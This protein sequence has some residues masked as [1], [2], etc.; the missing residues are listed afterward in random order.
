MK[1]FI[2]VVFIC[3]I[4]SVVLLQFNYSNNIYIFAESK[5]YNVTFNT[6]VKDINFE[7]INN[8][9]YVHSFTSYS[10]A[11]YINKKYTNNI[12]AQTFVYDNDF[13]YKNFLKRINFKCYKKYKVCGVEVFEGYSC[14]LNKYLLKNNHKFNL[15][16]A[17]GEEIKI[18]YPYILEGF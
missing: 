15:Q 2:C 17:V 5:G 13:D 3:V 11:K 10:N 9:N 16:I 4:G 8:G 7:T 18:G 1:R 6:S 14:F 12:I